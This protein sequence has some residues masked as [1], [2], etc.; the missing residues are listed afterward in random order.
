MLQ[1]GAAQREQEPGVGEQVQRLRVIWKGEQEASRVLIGNSNIRDK[2]PAG[3]LN[4]GVPNMWTGT[5]PD[6]ISD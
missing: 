5:S 2:V 4:L 1:N 6:R 3:N